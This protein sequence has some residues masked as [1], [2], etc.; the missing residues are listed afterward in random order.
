MGNQSGQHYTNGSSVPA[1]KGERL[2]D[3]SPAES[4]L[5]L[6]CLALPKPPRIC[7]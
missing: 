3:V 6:C 7:L 4:T 1:A 2:A 5:D